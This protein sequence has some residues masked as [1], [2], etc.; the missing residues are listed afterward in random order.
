MRRFIVCSTLLLAGLVLGG[1]TTSAPEGVLPREP[2]P[3]PPSLTRST[4]GPATR[5]ARTPVQQRR[6]LAVPPRLTTPRP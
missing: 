5:Q 3:P 6:T 4:A 2:V 1:C